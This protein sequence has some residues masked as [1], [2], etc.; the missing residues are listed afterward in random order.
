LVLL[1]KEANSPSLTGTYERQLPDGWLTNRYNYR[2]VRLWQEEPDPYL[3]AG[4]NLVPLAPLTNV[5][6]E[7]LPDLVRRM[8]A[9]INAEPEPRAAKLWTAT[10]L[11]MGLCYEEELISHLLEGVQ[12]MREST[13]YRAILREGREEGLIEGRNEGRI[14]EAHRLLLRLGEIRFGPPDEATRAAVEAIRDLDRLERMSD[15]VLDMSLNDW[16]DLL[17]TP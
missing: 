8:A 1:C 2:V 9:R 17:S 15:R 3:A 14:G 16:E 7:S 13:T 4:V 11:L 5:A 6:E 10:Y 12:N